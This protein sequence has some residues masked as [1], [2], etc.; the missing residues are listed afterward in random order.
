MASLMDSIIDVLEKEDAEYIRQI[1]LSEQK[2]PVIIKG[3][4][5]EL[6]RITE[7]ETEI[8]AVIQKLEKERIQIMKDIAE[9]TNRK[10]EDIK[11]G[12][13]VKMMDKRPAEQ[14]RLTALHD[15]LKGTMDRIKQVNEQN[16][17]LLEDS[18]EMVQFEMNLLQ[19]LKTAPE[20]ADYNSSA[21][22]TGTIMG[23]GTK[24]FDAKH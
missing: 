8:V 14:A 19:S 15:K 4:L 17:E 20:T 5:D 24:R 6:N 13:L 16:R 1:A 11:L 7:A 22:A 2:T 23:S 12:E 9:V 3:D 10:A 18:L 21:Y